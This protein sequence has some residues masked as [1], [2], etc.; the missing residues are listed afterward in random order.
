MKYANRNARLSM[1]SLIS[2][3]S[4]AYTTTPNVLYPRHIRR[5]SGVLLGI[6]E[7]NVT[8]EMLTL[9]YGGLH[10]NEEGAQADE[11]LQP[12]LL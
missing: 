10:L 2:T 1:A 3:L 9:P 4:I 5:N 8:V 7:F 11:R 12:P 6:A